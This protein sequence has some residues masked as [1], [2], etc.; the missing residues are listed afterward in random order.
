MHTNNQLAAPGHLTH[1]CGQATQKPANARAIY[2]GN[3]WPCLANPCLA[4]LWP[5]RSSGTG[6]GWGYRTGHPGKCLEPHKARTHAV[7]ERVHGRLRDTAYSVR[8]RKLGLISWPR[9]NHGHA[10][11]H[12]HLRNSACFCMYI[13]T[14]ARCGTFVGVFLFR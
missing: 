3:L 8:P 12:D 13:Q 11:G 5:G 6:H 14:T 2:F 9:A 1:K 4:R 7:G 10:T